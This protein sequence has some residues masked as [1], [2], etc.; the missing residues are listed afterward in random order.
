MHTPGIFSSLQS[1][2]HPYLQFTTNLDIAGIINI[3]SSINNQELKED[4]GK[5]RLH[6]PDRKTT[7]LCF[8]SLHSDTTEGELG[9][10]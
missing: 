2:Y 5:V 8:P 10:L 4:V 7:S 9:L 1:L 6:I 3:A